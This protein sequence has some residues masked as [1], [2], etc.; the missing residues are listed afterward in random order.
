MPVIT[1]NILLWQQANRHL[2]GNIVSSFSHETRK[3]NNCQ[4]D[5][6]INGKYKQKNDGNG[7]SDKN[8][9]NELEIKPKIISGKRQYGAINFFSSPSSSFP[10]PSSLFLLLLLFFFFFFFFYSFF[11]LKYLENQKLDSRF[12]Q[13]TN[14]FVHLSG[15]H[16]AHVLLSHVC[17][18]PQLS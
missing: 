12:P 7:L 16:T 10:S 17:S 6:W 15:D 9:S 2:K 8:A 5:Q 3:K 18:Y 13:S 4:E 1:N 14:W 11:L